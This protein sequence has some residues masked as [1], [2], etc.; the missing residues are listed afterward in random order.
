MSYQDNSHALCLGL[1]LLSKQ[2]DADDFLAWQR[3]MG[4]PSH[5]TKDMAEEAISLFGDDY[6]RLEVIQYAEGYVDSLGKA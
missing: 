5:Y 4:L 1:W 6:D 3:E 2:D